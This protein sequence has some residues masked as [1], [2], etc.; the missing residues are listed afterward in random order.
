[1]SILTHDEIIKAIDEGRIGI[2]PYDPTAVGPASID[3]RLGRSFRG[4][5]K[6]HEAVDVLDDTDYQTFTELVETDAYMLMPGESV[7]GITLETISLSP[8]LCGWLEG[9]S[10]FARMGLTVH[11]TASFMQPGISNRQVLEMN[12]VAPFPL[13]LHAGTRICQFIFQEAKGEAS[14]TG[15]FVNQQVP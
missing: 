11:V 4:F 9:R 2:D 8:S 14:Y 15:R 1:M 5:R 13:V 12:N 3:L 6:I 10:R 7:L